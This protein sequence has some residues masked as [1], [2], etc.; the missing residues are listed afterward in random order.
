MKIFNNFGMVP[1]TKYQTPGAK[2]TMAN[3]HVRTASTRF[4]PPNVQTVKDL[5]K[6]IDERTKRFF[7]I[8]VSAIL[9][10]LFLPLN[11]HIIIEYRHIFS[12]P[13]NMHIIIKLFFNEFWEIQN[14]S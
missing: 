6:R 13:L 3:G 5:Y 7:D 14:N 11:M 1:S 2:Q 9:S 4:L 12:S 10:H 8:P